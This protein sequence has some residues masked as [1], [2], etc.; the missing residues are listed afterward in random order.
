MGSSFHRGLTV[1]DVVPSQDGWEWKAYVAVDEQHVYHKCRF[2][3]LESGFTLTHVVHVTGL[4]LHDARWW[5]VIDGK[6]CADEDAALRILRI[7]TDEL[8]IMR[9]P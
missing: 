3:V 8:A 9:K 7:V 2:V 1:C 5:F 6:T 4:E